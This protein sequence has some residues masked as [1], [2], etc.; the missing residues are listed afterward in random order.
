MTA[1]QA[2]DL[3]HLLSPEARSRQVSPLKGAFKYFKAPGM[4]FLGGGLPVP[5]LF[6]IERLS[7]DI[8]AAPFPQGIA[9]KVTDD[10]KS[11]IAITKDPCEC[12]AHHVE[13]ARSLQYGWTDGA[14]ELVEFLKEHTVQIHAPPYADW[15]L[16]TLIG[17]TE[18]W[19]STLR[20]FTTRGE[21][22]LVEEF[23]FS[24][25]LETAYALGLQTVAV[26]MDEFGIIPEKLAVMMDCWVGPKPK[27]L[28]TIPTGQNPTG[29][30]LSKE[31]RQA[32]YDIAVKHDFLI[33]EDEPYY[34][35]QMDE[36][37]RDL[38]LRAKKHPHSHEEFVKSMVLSF[39][40][41]DV[42]GRVVRLD[43]VSKVLAPGLRLGWIVAQSR[44]LERYLRLHEVS[45]Q[46]PSGLSQTAVNGILREWGQPG[47]LDWLINLRSVYTHNRDVAIDAVYK[48]LPREVTSFVPPKAGMFFTIQIDAS[49]H[50]RFDTD[51]ERDPIR[52]ETAIY[53]EC[54]QQGVLLIPGSWFKAKGQS[55]PP[56]T[57]LP[58][59]PHHKTHIFFR[60]TYA[61][62]PLPELV[63]GVEK[64]GKALRAQFAL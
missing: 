54:I 29:S 33:V 28:Y 39:L 16:I 21:T 22:I 59:N 1:P 55:V 14:P 45:I 23:T 48:Y 61:A 62:V 27:L 25:A 58:E 35:L 9:A 34:Y 12:D 63:I 43:S 49:K 46:C 57:S 18:S 2:K 26:P 31:R 32:V 15:D 19:D 5:D 24:S 20:T 7:M 60:G 3:S 42:E 51:F 11:V 47:Y 6:P 17:N 38:E 13:L 37:T 64:F 52:V 41:L 56:Q 50:P 53:D 4:S 36:Y 44:L 40:S 10:I 30:C 8:P